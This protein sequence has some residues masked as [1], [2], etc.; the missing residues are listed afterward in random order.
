VRPV[1]TRR[2]VVIGAGVL[3][4]SIAARLAAAGMSVT[5]LDQDEPGRGTSRWSFAWVNSNDKGPKPYHDLN[6]AGL[7]AWAE[8]APGLDGAAWYRPAGNLELATSATGRA[9]LAA[10]VRRLT[11]WGYPARLVD[12]AEAAGL[13]PA[14][15]PPG[16]DAAAAWFPG[17]AYLLT[18][19][20]IERLVAR[21][22]D[23]G[24]S[25][26]TGDRGRVT[27]LSPGQVR[28][29]TGQVLSTDEIVCCAG[30]WTSLLTA[31]ASPTRPVPLVAWDTPRSPAPELVVR[32]G[33]VIPAVPTRVLHAPA[34]FLRP[35]SGGM[36]H[37][38]A[39]DTPVDLHTPEAELRSLAAELLHRARRTV[40]GLDQARIV[41]YRVC[42]RPL[43]A[44]GQSIVGRLP[45]AEWLYVAVTHSGVT[46]AAHLSR[47][48]A[49][50]LA[51]GASSAELA[52]FRP[53]R[54]AGTALPITG[55]ITGPAIGR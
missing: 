30:R 48:I 23:R 5:L 27:G 53:D 22:A 19:P 11:G 9:E 49:A 12:A 52:P 37:L 32:V 42:V 17:E 31:L 1:Q 35:H 4:A 41:T 28:T 21:A 43:P 2:C 8:V 40:R 46:L 29:A 13:E 36:L 51:T 47:L 10:R 44:D 38:E 7:R 15:L 55:N 33:P 6:Y 24:A 20:L 18:E 25:V 14:L 26:L 54:F 39:P 50:E 16:P 34:I 45:G 3:G